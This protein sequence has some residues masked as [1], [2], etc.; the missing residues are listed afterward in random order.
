MRNQETKKF[1]LQA[2]ATE[3]NNDCAAIMGHSWAYGSINE[4]LCRLL[5]SFQLSQVWGKD[6]I[7][8]AHSRACPSV[9]YLDFGK[10]FDNS[11]FRDKNETSTII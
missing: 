1:F 2:H 9:N 10:Y 11:K 6:F 4:Q 5:G 7:L 3:L 8:W